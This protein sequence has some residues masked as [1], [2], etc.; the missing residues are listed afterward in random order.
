MMGYQFKDQER[1]LL[2]TLRDV[3]PMRMYVAAE[4]V[5]PTYSKK[6]ARRKIRSIVDKLKK[7]PY[8]LVA[9]KVVDNNKSTISLTKKGEEA[10]GEIEQ[11]RIIA[12]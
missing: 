9:K 11:R 12:L 5:F 7:P 2:V 10:V 8:E 6:N 4:E 1:E 3:G